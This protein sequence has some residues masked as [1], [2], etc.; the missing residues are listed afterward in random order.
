M[1]ASLKVKTILA[2]RAMLV[3]LSAGVVVESKGA[4]VSGA[5]S[6]SRMVKVDLE[7][8]VVSASVVLR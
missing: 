2:L 6:L 4:V 8:N 5:P 7:R 1:T 3:V